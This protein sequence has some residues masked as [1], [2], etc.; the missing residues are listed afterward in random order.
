[1][2]RLRSIFDRYNSP[3][4]GLNDHQMGCSAG[5][6]RIPMVGQDFI[7]GDTIFQVRKPWACASQFPDQRFPRQ[8]QR[9]VHDI[10][11]RSGPVS[12]GDCIGTVFKIEMGGHSN[13]NPLAPSGH[14]L[15]GAMV[16][17]FIE[18][19]TGFSGNI[20]NIKTSK[21]YRRGH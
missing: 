3:G 20:V 9:A 21:R 19:L 15:A 13:R 14:Q 7:K 2:V 5:S 12:I 1:M 18:W 8:R 10:R 16:N 4:K 11:Q 6:G 17:P